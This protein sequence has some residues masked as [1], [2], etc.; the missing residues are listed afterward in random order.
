MAKKYRFEIQVDDADASRK[1]RD[2][3]K[4]IG[5]L[6]DT[7]KSFASRLASVF[8][9]AGQAAEGFTARTAKTE[10]AVKDV[11]TAAKATGDAMASSFIKTTRIIDATNAGLKTTFVEFTRVT[12]AGYGF[13]RAL[14]AII[15]KSRQAA[16][17]Q[18]GMFAAQSYAGGAFLEAQSPSQL[19]LG[20]PSRGWNFYQRP[21]SAFGM[22]RDRETDTLAMSRQAY[23]GELN[24]QAMESIEGYSPRNPEAHEKHRMSQGNSRI[25]EIKKELAEE[26]S[27]R[28]K[29]INDVAS[30]EQKV[31]AQKQSVAKQEAD[32]RTREARKFHTE[33]SRMEDEGIARFEKNKTAESQ[34]IQMATAAYN[35]MIEQKI[36][37]G[38]RLNTQEVA[39][40]RQKVKQMISEEDRFQDNFSKHLSDREIKQIV[41]NKRMENANSIRVKSAL[42]EAG[43]EESAHSTWLRSMGMMIARFAVYHV[44]IGT[45]VSLYKA[46]AKA[47]ED[48]KKAQSD[49]LHDA[50]DKMAGL[51]LLSVQ[52][53][54]MPDEALRVVAKTNIKAGG[55]GFDKTK[56]FLESFSEGAQQHIGTRITK[57]QAFGELA[58]EALKFAH[59]HGLEVGPAGRFLA[60]VAGEKDRRGMAPGDAKDDA[61]KS[62]GESIGVLEQGVGKTSTL[63]SQMQQFHATFGAMF[64]SFKD[65]AIALSM[66]A[67]GKPTGEGVFTAARATLQ[68]L[69]SPNAKLKPFLEGISTDKG[70]PIWDKAAAEGNGALDANLDFMSEVMPAINSRIDKMGLTDA[71]RDVFLTAIGFTQKTGQPGA[72]GLFGAKAKRT[73]E[74]KR[75]AAAGLNIGQ[76]IQARAMQ[77]VAQA[78][79]QQAVFEG[80]KLDQARENQDVVGAQAMGLE[81][82]QRERRWHTRKDWQHRTL[83]AI[84]GIG[85]A[86]TDEEDI[87]RFEAQQEI[88]QRLNAKKEIRMIGGVPTMQYKYK[89][90][91]GKDQTYNAFMEGS[92]DPDFGKN[93]AASLQKLMRDA[94]LAT[95]AQA[96]ANG[97]GAIVDPI[98]A[99]LQRV[100]NAVMNLQRGAA[101]PPI[102]PAPAGLGVGRPPNANGDP[103]GINWNNLLGGFFHPAAAP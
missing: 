76:D 80:R 41:A 75:A 51:N 22:M 13:A 49:L 57:D 8:Q 31:S 42:K 7:A 79:F 60:Q 64:K 61:M 6:D 16:Q 58:P 102:I 19:Q 78:E 98:V 29:A 92:V 72:I 67:Q 30:H 103:G 53:G 90:V 73:E 17:A 96:G 14:D 100:E 50:H 56:E 21:A 24:R 44:A 84:T 55:P 34:K 54:M 59:L 26:A 66:I 85:R 70:K 5:K 71:Q 47:A 97:P 11:G 101:P 18:A 86:H 74:E 95:N 32:V 9:G 40:E 65:E 45:A 2:L 12:G 69:I 36:R 20:G 81:R 37:A 82:M 52:M 39:G 83:L 3:A 27:V 68:Q 89:D 10:K 93:S 1:I 88:L 15:A 33:S 91:A 87:L 99:G 4:S 25:D 46:F 62:F 28:R 94:G 63:L 23:A 43:L 77:P 35:R 38:E 48:A